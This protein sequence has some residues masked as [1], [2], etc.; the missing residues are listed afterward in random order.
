[1]TLSFPRVSGDAP[2]WRRACIVTPRFSPRERGCALLEECDDAG[3]SGFPRVSG[4][5]PV[6]YG[7]FQRH[8]Q[9]SPRER[10]C[11]HA[12]YDARIRSLVFP[13]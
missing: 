1:M 13:A 7:E 5:A 6:N 11:A 10:G 8:G 12:D 4:D 2:E 3:H 9:F